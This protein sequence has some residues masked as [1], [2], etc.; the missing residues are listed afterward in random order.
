M[1]TA[2]TWTIKG[3]S[4][5]TRDAVYEA[6]HAQGLTLGDWIDGAL[7]RAAREALHPTPAAA[8]RGDVTEV[9]REQLA[10][11]IARLEALEGEARS[12]RVDAGPAAMEIHSKPLARGRRGL[13]DE[14]RGRITELHRAGHSAYAIS[15]EVGVAYTTAR[16]HVRALGAA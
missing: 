5:A 14:T 13:S 4:D 11:V 3:V 1:A 12:K 7:A 6:S 15:K 2:R 8:T 10:P 9:I 16:A